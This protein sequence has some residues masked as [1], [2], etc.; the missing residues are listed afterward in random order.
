[1][2]HKNR[3]ITIWDYEHLILQQFPKIYK[4]KCLNHTSYTIKENEDGKKEVVTRFLAPG[5]VL[6]IVIPDIVN[7]NVFDLYKPR[8]S[9]ATLNEIQA[10]VNERNSLHVNVVVANPEYEEVTVS[11]KVKFRK[12]FDESFYLKKLNE[13][14]TRLLSPWAFKQT[15]K[16][17]F[18]T[19]L[20]RSTL[21][22]YIEKLQYVD[23]VEDVMMKK[24]GKPYAFVSP[25]TPIAILVSARQHE[26][27]LASE[28]CKETVET[29]EICQK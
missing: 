18:G 24:D 13:D 28:T 11:L 26:L 4:V 9:K 6:D 14:I 23:Y 29:E 25:E 12:G 5:H 20:H 2:R 3:A 16:I 19:T 7:T 22:H 17:E 27:S 21:I 1:L 15:V 8:V 10:F